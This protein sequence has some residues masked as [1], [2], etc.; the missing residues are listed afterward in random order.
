MLLLEQPGLHLRSFFAGGMILIIVGVLDDMH[1]LPTLARFIAQIMASTIMAIWGGV[2]IIDFGNIGFGPGPIE[3]GVFMLPLTIFATVGVINALNMI[4]GLNGLAGFIALVTTLAM[5]LLCWIAGQVHTMYLLLLLGAV[6]SAFLAFNCR[7]CKDQCALTFMGDAGSMFLGFVLCWFFIQLSQGEARV[8]APVTAL[9]IFAVP[10]IDTVTMMLR[11]IV[12]GRSPFSADREHVHHLL[13]KAGFGQ[14]ETV[15]IIVLIA[16]VFASIGIAAD[17]AGYSEAQMFALFL[18]CFA[19]YF[20]ITLRAWKF[21]R[22]LK[23][24]RQ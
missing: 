11:R 2:Q 6:I 1:E 20:G 4:D 17:L 8:M 23:W 21:M 13:L 3:L 15:M 5:A 9:W 24:V 19:L 7:Y 18:L 14:R 22:L 16:L 10:L 12:K